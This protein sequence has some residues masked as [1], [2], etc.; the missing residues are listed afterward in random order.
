[1]ALRWRKCCTQN[2][3]QQGA[4]SCGR[5]DGVATSSQA[6]KCTTMMVRVPSGGSL[7][8]SLRCTS[9]YFAN[10]VPQTHDAGI[11]RPRA[12]PGLVRPPHTWEPHINRH[13]ESPGVVRLQSHPTTPGL[14]RSRLT[15]LCFV[16]RFKNPH[17]AECLQSPVFVFFR[18]WGRRVLRVLPTCRCT[19]ARRARPAAA[20]C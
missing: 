8:S 17:Y 7:M 1:M 15:S 11:N 13:R 16:S 18:R 3:A 5:W 9:L 2:T 20:A 6:T 14:A 19:F 10:D 4:T 12:Q